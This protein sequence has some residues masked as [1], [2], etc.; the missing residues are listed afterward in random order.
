MINTN[1]YN[2]QL[3]GSHT[4]AGQPLGATIG[5]CTKADIIT[6]SNM[7]LNGHAITVSIDI[8][9]RDEKE[10]KKHAAHEAG[11][12]VHPISADLLKPVVDDFKSKG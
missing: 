10:M 12:L 3:D 1:P 11:T 4:L 7:D 9:K 6:A 5:Y 2:G 8:W